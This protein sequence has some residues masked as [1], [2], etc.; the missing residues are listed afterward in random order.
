MTKNVV[1]FSNAALDKLELRLVCEPFESV[2]SVAIAF[3]LKSN[4]TLVDVWLVS[5]ASNNGLVSALLVF[6]AIVREAA[7]VGST[8][9]AFD[10]AIPL[11]IALDVEVP[12]DGLMNAFDSAMLVLVEIAA[13]DA[14]PDAAADQAAV[15]MSLLE[16]NVLASLTPG[17]DEFTT[18]SQD[19]TL[20][21]NME[22]AV[23]AV[24]GS[25]DRALG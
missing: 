21:S 14:E 8:D 15:L 25:S 16:R 22:D 20:A 10:A 2:S 7:D 13:L 5:G 4:D 11:R 23:D 19:A 12:G 6:G 24:L 9:S 18:E 3:L 17:I 1:D